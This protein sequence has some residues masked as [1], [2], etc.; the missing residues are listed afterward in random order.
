MQC[1]FIC[2]LPRRSTQGVSQRYEP[3]AASPAARFQKERNEGFLWCEVDRIVF[4]VYLHQLENNEL[5]CR[6]LYDNKVDVAKKTRLAEN[7][8]PPHDAIRRGGPDRSGTCPA[9]DLQQR[10]VPQQSRMLESPDSYLHDSGRCLHTELPFLRHAHGT[11][12]SARRCRA[13]ATGPQREADGSSARC[14]NIR[15]T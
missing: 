12:A 14:R 13:R 6:K 2:F 15:Y 3:A 11:S 8:P 10:D 1:K 4:F 5:K 9:H 7:S